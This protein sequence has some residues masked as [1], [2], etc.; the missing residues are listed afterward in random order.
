VRTNLWQDVGGEAVTHFDSAAVPLKMAATRLEMAVGLTARLKARLNL[1]GQVGY[2][3]AVAGYTQV[4]QNAVAGTV[5]L[6][7][8]W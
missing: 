8:R 4:R 1:Y 5:G 3:F 6:R 2:T 7:Y